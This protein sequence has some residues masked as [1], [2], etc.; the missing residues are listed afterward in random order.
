MVIEAADDLEFAGEAATGPQALDMIVV[1]KPD[2]AV[3]DISLPQM[4]GIALARRLTDLCPSTGLIV[5]TAHEDR[6]YLDQALANGVRGYVLKKS[7]AECLVHAVRAVLAG[8]LYVDPAIAG[9]MFEAGRRHRYIGSPLLTQ[10][11]SDVL[12]LIASGLTTKEA[13]VRL[14]LSAKSIETYKARGATK[15]GAK[16]RSDIVRYA[17]AQGWLASV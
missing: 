12:R 10:R 17:S 4:N 13:A 6:V 9:R 3:I 11:E 15:I 7:D 1:A 8:G 16:S 14:D 2:V 5:L